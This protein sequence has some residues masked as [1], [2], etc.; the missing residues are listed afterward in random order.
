MGG[1]RGDVRSEGG[2][3]GDVEGGEGTVPVRMVWSVDDGRSVEMKDHVIAD[4][5]REEVSKVGDRDG[6]DR[7][8]ME[9]KVEMGV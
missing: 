1:V 5:V 2:A 8:R 7:G 9:G 4:Y 3:S 6:G